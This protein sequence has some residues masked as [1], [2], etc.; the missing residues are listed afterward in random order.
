MDHRKAAGWTALIFCV[1]VAIATR[2]IAVPLILAAWFAALARPLHRRLSER[3]SPGGSAGLLTVA[4]VA[5]LASLI[6]LLY[7]LLAGAAM[8]LADELG[9]SNGVREA[10]EALVSQRRLDPSPENLRKL[11][12]RHGIEGE[13]VKYGGLLGLGTLLF[14]FF[15]GLAA[16]GLLAGGQQLHAWLR[17]RSP[18]QPSHFDRMGAAFT[19]TGRGLATSIGLTCAIQG[20]L[21]S[22]TFLALGVPRALMLGFVCGL[23]AILPLV[24]TP[25]VWIPV[26]AG[27]FLTDH[28]AKGVILLIVGGGVI[29]A[30]EF[31]IG[32]AL[33]RVG[34]LKLPAEL[35][36]VSM[37]GGVLGLGPAGLVLGPLAFRLAREGL[38]IWRD[39][40]V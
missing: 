11:A 15:L 25:L 14:F 9:R 28:A 10:C 40:R 19:E 30:I 37:F 35:V 38:D 39:A 27:L 22:I 1:A 12:H 36:L 5:I 32:P 3:L 2:P 21:C 7:V 17:E 31:F 18:L 23:F 33:A 8:G 6:A 29:G 26:A 4:L 16:W 24:G 13:L 34:R 20:A